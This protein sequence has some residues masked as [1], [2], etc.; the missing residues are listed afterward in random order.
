MTNKVDKI[1][2][3]TLWFPTSVKKSHAR[4]NPI[5][6]ISKQ[7]KCILSALGNWSY[8]FAR[9]DWGLVGKNDLLCAAVNG[10]KLR[11]IFSRDDDSNW[12]GAEREDAQGMVR[13]RDCLNI[14]NSSTSRERE[15]EWEDGTVPCTCEISGE[16]WLMRTCMSRADK[17]ARRGGDCCCETTLGVPRYL[18]VICMEENMR[19]SL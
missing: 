17:I 9:K 1:R 10:K 7:S 18:Y 2:L 12:R 13:S 6:S 5:S 14:R 15:R 11:R 8:D 16:S 19:A 3:K 4:C